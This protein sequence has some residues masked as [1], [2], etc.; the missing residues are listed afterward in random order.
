MTLRE[1]IQSD[2]KDAL[3]AHDAAKLSAIRM[4]WSAVKQ[5]EVD[6][7]ITADDKVIV[8]IIAKAVK[9]REDSVEQYRKGGREDLASK[10]LHEKEICEAYLP[11][12]LSEEEVAKVIDEAI[13]ATGAAGMAGMGKVMGY[14]KPKLMGRADMGRVSAA[15]RAKLLQK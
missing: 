6:E 5:K 11:K 8:A 14:V 9:E 10:E 13:A 15:V 3:R 2:M 4:L 1:K 7:R 12:Q